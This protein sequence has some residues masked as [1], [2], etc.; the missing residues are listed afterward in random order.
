MW[1]EYQ[2][3]SWVSYMWD[4]KLKIKECDWVRWHAQQ[5][6]G[7][8]PC[9]FSHYSNHNLILDLFC[10]WYVT[11]NCVMCNCV[12]IWSVTLCDYSL[13]YLSLNSETLYF[14]SQV[15]SAQ[16]KV[17]RQGKKQR[18]S[19]WNNKDQVQ[20][21]AKQSKAKQSKA[22]QSKAKQSK[23]KQSKAK[24]S[25][26]KQSKAKQSKA[27]QSKAKQS[28]NQWQKSVAKQSVVFCV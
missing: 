19:K 11:C 10:T 26:A 20:S 25:K 24:K 21:K 9:Y 2:W 28:K 4:V 6:H 13:S 15:K 5:K 27:K 8:S 14:W 3:G 7:G 16:L 17:C 18:Q 1:C 22:K 12:N 23:A